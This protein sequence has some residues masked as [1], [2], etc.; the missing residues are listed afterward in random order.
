MMINRKPNDLKGQHILAQGNAL[1]INAMIKIV[2]AI[3]FTKE[4]FSYRTKGM[5]PISQQIIPFYS[6]RNKFIT[7]FILFSRTVSAAIPLP[8]ALPRAIAILPFQGE[9]SQKLRS[10]KNRSKY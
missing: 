10:E 9:E 6:V 5:I 7:I 1:G 4:K 8:G 3:M 2:R